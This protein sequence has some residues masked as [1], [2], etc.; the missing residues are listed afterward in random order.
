MFLRFEKD[1]NF[2]RPWISEMTVQIKWPINS[3]EK[4]ALLIKH[5]YGSWRGWL[6]H[7]RGVRSGNNNVCIHHMF[8]R[9][10]F[11]FSFLVR[12]WWLI[13]NSYHNGW[14]F[15]SIQKK[16]NFGVDC[17]ILIE[18]PQFLDMLWYIFFHKRHFFFRLFNEMRQTSTKVGRPL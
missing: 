1:L 14:T 16:K 12:Y 18:F 15:F 17:S 3:T 2:S 6:C 10:L 13:I 5:T 7:R 11:F 9:I 8:S 4:Y